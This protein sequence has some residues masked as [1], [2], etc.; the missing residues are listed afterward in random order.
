MALD[1]CL[2]NCPTANATAS[3]YEACFTD[4]GWTAPVQAVLPVPVAIAIA[5]GETHAHRSIPVGCAAH[6]G[7]W[8]GSQGELT[9]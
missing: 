8:S 7:P 5:G 9:I 4:A 6:G 2:A 3:C 1:Q